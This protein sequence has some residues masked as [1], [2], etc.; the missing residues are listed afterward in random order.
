MAERVIAMGD[1]DYADLLG[2]AVG[3]IAKEDVP[4]IV[5]NLLT[6][7]ETDLELWIRPE[8]VGHGYSVEWTTLEDDPVGPEWRPQ[9]RDARADP[10]SG[11]TA[12][13][14]GRELLSR[15]TSF[16]RERMPSF[17]VDRERIN[18]F[19]VD[20]RYLFKQYF[21]QDDVFA[22]LRRYYNEDEYRFEVP[23]DAFSEVQELLREHFYDPVVVDDP[24]QFCVVY[25]KY[26]DHPDVLF[27]A[28]VLQRSTGDYH[29]FLMKDQLSVEQAVKNGGTRLVEADVEIRL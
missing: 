23:K 16:V 7:R 13:R 12:D 25:P 14:S 2:G 3:G 24:E 18:L 17:E 27:K 28:S 26:A 8:R 29:V 11:D 9:R 21:E 19:A 1:D 6:D 20:D 22:E 15:V 5:A 4:Q 10:G